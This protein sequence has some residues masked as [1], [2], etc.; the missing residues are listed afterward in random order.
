M[1]NTVVRIGL[2]M[3]HTLGFYRQ[4]L[5]RVKTF[6]V[7]RP[8]WVFSPIA[9]DKRAIEMALPLRCDGY[10]A[11]IFTQ[12][13]AQ[14]L[15]ALRKPVVSVAGV[16]SDLPLPHVMVDH[17]EVGRQAARHMLE[18][19]VRQFGYVG[20]PKHEFSVERERG[21]REVVVSAGYSVASFHE[22]TQRVQDPTGMW[23]WNKPLMTWLN[24]LSKPIGILAS[25]DVQGAQVSEYCRQ[26]GLRV[27]DEIAIVGVDNDDL[28]CE[29][30]RPS[31]SS[32][33]LAGER[34]GFE[35]AGLLD[36]WLR[37]S[38]PGNS[39]VVLPPAGVVVRQSSDLLAVPDPR[40][41]AALRFIREHADQP[42]Q[43]RDVLQEV[44]VARRALERRFRKWLQRS[45]SEEIH[46]VHLERSRQL[47]VQTDMSL[48]AVALGSGFR[49]GRQLSVAY[50]REMGLT[51][52]AFRRQYRLRS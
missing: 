8:N 20:Y 35:A 37:G 11:H 36:K 28:L 16:M 50:R 45:I 44:P 29:L 14:S 39:V 21:F 19:G 43:V 5:R 6:A 12:P 22:R 31:L 17:P 42:I 2:V 48:A 15:L 41:S 4:I 9:P 33:A 18:R 46:R 38:P 23:N 10:L 49:D 26:L 47:L 52:S 40:V 27:P 51:P 30:S 1:A 13:L 32:V 25:N 3:T 24:G 7:E 34:I